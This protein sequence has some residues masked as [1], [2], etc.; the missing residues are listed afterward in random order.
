MA[1]RKSGVLLH[2]TSLPGGDGLGHEAFAFVD[3]LV[4]AGCGIWQML[5][6]SPVGPGNSPY[7]ARSAF[8]LDPLLISLDQLEDAGLLS[9]GSLPPFTL[10]DPHRVDFA[11]E[12]A[13]REPYL[14]AA[15]SEFLATGGATELRKFVYANAWL[16][17]YATFAALRELNAEPWWLWPAEAPDH[18]RPNED[19]ALANEVKF[20]EFLQWCLDSQWAAL[21]TYAHDRGVDLYGDVPIFVDLDSSDVWQNKGLFKLD[22]DGM[23]RVVA[24]VPPDLF[25]ETGQRWG[26]P[27]YSWPAMRA[28]GFSWWIE[29]LRRTFSLFDAARIDHFRGFEGAWEIPAQEETAVFGHWEPGP[30]RELF[31]AA[32]AALDVLPIIVEDLGVITDEV[33]TLRDALGYPGMAILQFAFGGD[34]TNPYLPENHVENQVVFTGTHD[35]DTTAGWYRHASTAERVD[36]CRRLQTNARGI[37]DDLIRCAY[38]SVADTALI[39]MQDVLRLGSEARMNI[40]GTAEGN[41]EWRFTWDQL[42]AGRAKWLAALARETRRQAGAAGAK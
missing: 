4:E 9:R 23:P 11:R 13:Q 15:F 41:W 12:R 33:R 6:P 2:L 7:A 31:D 22:E 5:P 18:S 3:F 30:G 19:Q 40:P 32:S 37:V 39:P 34:E 17:P 28:E 16:R 36:V 42:P 14:R 35:N 1:Q 10:P 25:S 38:E 24:G 8:A 26:N 21:R 29:R 27:H 20:Q